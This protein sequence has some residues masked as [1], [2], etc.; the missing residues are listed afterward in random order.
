MHA[1]LL[2]MVCSFPT[3]I[4]QEAARQICHE[5]IRLHLH[6]TMLSMP[7][8]C[9][10]GLLT[11]LPLRCTLA[12]SLATCRAALLSSSPCCL[13]AVS[14]SASLAEACSATCC[15]PELLQGQHSGVGSEHT[16]RA[17]S[18][19]RLCCCWS[20]CTFLHVSCL[21]EGVLILYVVGS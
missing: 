21:W 17:V 1:L 15:V 2:A 20:L 13:Q 5:E 9:D 14:S 3:V 6:V 18:G 4:A 8:T 12:C 7:P 10:S 11:S 16:C 19:G